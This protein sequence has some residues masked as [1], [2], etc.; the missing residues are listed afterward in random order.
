MQDVFSRYLWTEALMDKRPETVAKAFE[1][2]LERAGTSPRSVTSDQGPEFDGPFKDML[3]SKGI[4]RS[5]KRPADKNAIATIDVAIGNLKKALVR[6]TRRLGSNDWASRLQ[7]VTKGQNNIPNDEYLDKNTPTDARTNK[8]L[9]EK[10]QVKNAEF[11]AIKRK[12]IKNEPWISN[13][14]A[15]FA[16]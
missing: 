14:Q 16:Q 8:K 13:G 6:D 11:T 15:N 5:Q 12:R 9:I 2:I 7:K 10:L 4:E 1:D 3:D